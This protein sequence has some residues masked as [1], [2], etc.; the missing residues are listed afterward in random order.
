MFRAKRTK[1]VLRSPKE[2]NEVKIKDEARA[3]S[4]WKQNQKR[5]GF[6]LIL[7]S[8][9]DQMPD[10]SGNMWWKE[11]P[12]ESS[13]QISRHGGWVRISSSNVDLGSEFTHISSPEVDPRDQRRD[14]FNLQRSISE[15][16]RESDGRISSPKVNFESK[17]WRNPHFEDQRM[18]E[19]GIRGPKSN[20]NAISEIRGWS[21]PGSEDQNPSC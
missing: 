18:T 17:R 5:S 6:S 20:P 15:A 1:G 12:A 16:G 10:L 14:K 3:E 7:N 21:N 11:S 2:A 19:S 13:S 4:L 8:E 9:S